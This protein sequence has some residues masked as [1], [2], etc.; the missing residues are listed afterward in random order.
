L[1]FLEK[2]LIELQVDKTLHQEYSGLESL[3]NT[4]LEKPG[5]GIEIEDFANVSIDNCFGYEYKW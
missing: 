3:K 5:I 1:D 4:I 2:P